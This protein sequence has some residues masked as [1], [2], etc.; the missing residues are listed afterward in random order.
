METKTNNALPAG[1]E[2]AE[3]SSRRTARIA[4]FRDVDGNR[5]EISVHRRPEGMTTTPD[6]VLDVLPGHV[7]RILK[8]PHQARQPSGLVLRLRGSRLDDRDRR[9]N[10]LIAP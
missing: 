10:L 1:D 2:A 4:A 6:L 7:D 8:A 5:H 3:L 9:G